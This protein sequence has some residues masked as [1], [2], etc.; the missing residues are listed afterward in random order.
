MRCANHLFFVVFVVFVVCPVFSH[1]V[2][3]DGVVIG[4]GSKV[5]LSFVVRFIIY[6]VNAHV[7]GEDIF[8]LR[9]FGALPLRRVRGGGFRVDCALRQSTLGFHHS[10]DHFDG[11]RC[12]TLG[13]LVQ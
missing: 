2:S 12:V 13:N 4:N 10:G 7:L 11:L 3:W 8:A 6:T 1:W 5:Q 9:L